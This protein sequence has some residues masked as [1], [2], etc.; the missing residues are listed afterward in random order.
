MNKQLSSAIRID[1]TLRDSPALAQNYLTSAFEWSTA[2]VSI[3]SRADYLL[4]KLANVN[5]KLLDLH[6]FLPSLRLR[7]AVFS[8]RIEGSRATIREI[9]LNEAGAY[10]G[11]Y[12]R[13]LK[14]VENYDKALNYGI[15]HLKNEPLSL[16]LLQNV[17]QILEHD[18][19]SY[20]NHPKDLRTKLKV[21]HSSE[22]SFPRTNLV[23]SQQESLKADL[24]K[25]RWVFQDKMLPPLIQ[26]ALSHFQFVALSPSL[27]SNR[28]VG[29]LLIPLLL[30]ERE[31]SLHFN[32]QSCSRPGSKLYDSTKSYL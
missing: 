31:E 7:E 25:L 30:I 13:E 4:G 26:C 16:P 17:Q 19:N 22:T 15:E 18:I 3:L 1:K 32:K 10:V 8:N 11:L 24:E 21:I 12:P 2:L 29:S 6:L 20:Q 28:Q 27:G 14:Q 5:S 9:C 23:F